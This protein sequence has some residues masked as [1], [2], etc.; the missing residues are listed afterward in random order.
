M[1]GS[2]P[3]SKFAPVNGKGFIKKDDTWINKVS[4]MFLTYLVNYFSSLS[5][6][7]GFS[8]PFSDKM[9]NSL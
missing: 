3:L 5:N 6:R 9:K 1:F 2:K 7:S 8:Q 4:Q